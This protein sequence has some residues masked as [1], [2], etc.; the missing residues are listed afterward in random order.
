MASFLFGWWFSG[1]IPPSDREGQAADRHSS[2]LILFNPAAPLSR[3]SR[4]ESRE[5]WPR[6]ATGLNFCWVL[7][8]AQKLFRKLGHYRAGAALQGGSGVVE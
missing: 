6:E 5:A 7:Y 4:A 1:R 3:L 8:A 2:V